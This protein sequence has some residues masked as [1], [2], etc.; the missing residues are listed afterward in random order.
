[1]NLEEIISS[2]INIGFPCVAAVYMAYINDK[3]DERHRA[4]E[5]DL[6]NALGE[7]TV[8]LTKISERVSNIE[9]D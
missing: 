5:K 2:I 3:Q 9:R 8:A 7:N 6:I 4:S 1:M